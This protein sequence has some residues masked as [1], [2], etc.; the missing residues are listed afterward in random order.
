[1]SDNPYRLPH[2]VLPSRYR[3]VLEPDLGAASYKGT[4]S[5]DVTAS[6]AV[7]SV[8]LNADE[9]EITSVLVGAAESPFRLDTTTE[10]LIIDASIDKGDTTID[11]AFTGTLKFTKKFSFDSHFVIRWTITDTAWVVVPGKNVSVPLRET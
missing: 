4:V 1:M 2:T 9:L 5:I 10:R 8:A 3:L 6:A 11:I 7:Q